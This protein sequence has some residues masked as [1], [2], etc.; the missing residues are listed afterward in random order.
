[1]SE[2]LERISAEV[3][4]VMTCGERAGRRRRQGGV[5]ERESVEEREEKEKSEREIEAIL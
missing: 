1:M 2:E 4:M 3:A 5:V